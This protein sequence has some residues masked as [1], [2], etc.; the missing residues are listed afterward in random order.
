MQCEV[1]AKSSLA[2]RNKEQI[3]NYFKNCWYLLET[4]KTPLSLSIS[5]FH[6]PI[7]LI[8]KEIERGGS[9]SKTNIC[10]LWEQLQKHMSDEYYNMRVI[11]DHESR[12]EKSMQLLHKIS[13]FN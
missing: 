13:I 10:C 1:L 7:I 4:N 3:V 9:Y 6:L 8:P 12:G 5:H 2:D 11:I